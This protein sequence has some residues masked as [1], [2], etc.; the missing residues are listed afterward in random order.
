MLNKIITILEKYFDFP[1]AE[2]HISR[3]LECDDFFELSLAHLKVAC[4]LQTLLTSRLGATEVVVTWINNTSFNLKIDGN[5]YGVRT[6]VFK[7]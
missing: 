3:K 7:Q 1:W 2:Y 6:A 5:T 4:Q